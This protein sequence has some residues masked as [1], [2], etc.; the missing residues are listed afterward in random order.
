MLIGELANAADTTIRA[1]R[2]YEQQGLLP[3]RRVPNG[4]RHYDESAVTW[5]R[6]IRRL[7][8]L[9]F[10]ADDIHAF[11]PCLD[12]DRPAGTTC[13]PA[14]PVIARQLAELEEKIAALNAMRAHL[15]ETLAHATGETTDINAHDP[16]GPGRSPAASRQ[17]LRFANARI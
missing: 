15:L 13:R 11:V 14:V 5:V 7:L 9:G 10:T 4:Y 12:A 17:R 1:L 3:P 8:S 2:Y 6:N 16:A